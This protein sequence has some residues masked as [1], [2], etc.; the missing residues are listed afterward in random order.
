M[1]H[2]LLPRDGTYYKANLHSHSNLSDGRLTP[3]ELRDLYRDHGYSIL[4]ITDHELMVDH[5]DLSQPGFLMIN[6]YEIYLRERM[7][8]PRIAKNCHINLIARTPTELRQI[9][10]DPKYLNYIRKNGLAVEDIPRVGDLCDRHYCPRDINRIIRTAAENG[11][12]VFYNHPSWSLETV[13]EFG[14][15]EGVFAMEVVNYG[16]SLEGFPEND[17]WAYDQMLRL[18]RDI[19][20]LANDDNHNKFP[21]GHPACDSFGGFNMICARELT[22]EAVIDALEKGRFYA[23]MGPTIEEMYVEDGKLHVRC[24]PA[25][26]IAARMLGRA[27]TRGTAFAPVGQ[28]ITEGVIPL[29]RDDAYIRV[30]V[31]DAHGKK[32]F[33]HAYRLDGLLD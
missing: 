6:G 20:C 28:T 19:W 22:Y 25:V 4:A 27:T 10:V 32:A 11:Y 31:T 3:A 9:A 1:R 5:T 17:A 7:D 24:S 26:S 15:Y 33:T 18:G 29:Q 30:E 14:K 16:S 12:L 2:D 13:E 23:S 21:V 8:A